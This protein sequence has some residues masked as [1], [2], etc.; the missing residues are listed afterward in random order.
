M[1]KPLATLKCGFEMVMYK[2][3][4]PMKLYS[5]SFT[6]PVGH[7][8]DQCEVTLYSTESGFEFR[9]GFSGT[10][11]VHPLPLEKVGAFVGALHGLDQSHLVHAIRRIAAQGDSHKIHE[12][13]HKT[14]PASWTWRSTDGASG[15]R[16]TNQTPK[17]SALLEREEEVLGELKRP[18]LGRRLT[19]TD[20]GSVVE[21][22]PFVFAKLEPPESIQS[23]E[24]LIFL[25]SARI[26]SLLDEPLV[27][28]PKASA[29]AAITLLIR[30]LDIPEDLTP[31]LSHFDDP[32]AFAALIAA[33][34]H[35]NQFDKSGFPYIEHPRRV[36]LNSQWSLDPATVP[37]DELSAGLQA[38]WLHDVI[39]DSRD[40]F[41][42][43]VGSQDLENWGFN[44]RVIFLVQLLTRSEETSSHNYYR[45][46]SG[47]PTARSVKLAD[48]ADNLASWR[49][50]LLDASTRETLITKYGKALAAL[51]FNDGKESWFSIRIAAFDE[52]LW[53]LFAR[54][55][56]H[57]ALRQKQDRSRDLRGLKISSKRNTWNREL[58]QINQQGGEIIRDSAW[59]ERKAALTPYDALEPYP[60]DSWFAALFI[61]HA[62]AEDT[63]SQEARDTAQ[64]LATFLDSINRAEAQFF[65]HWGWVPRDAN[66][67]QV[68]L[69]YPAAL[70]S[71]H[72]YSDRLKEV[73]DGNYSV[74]GDYHGG[75]EMLLAGATDSQLLDMG[76]IA[77]GE[78][79]P[80]WPS[81]A[82]KSVVIEIEMR[83]R[84]KNGK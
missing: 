75:Q 13:I 1:M 83:T 36:F 37:E 77:F 30:G 55:E 39:E 27:E 16:S 31:G 23:L 3:G 48:I 61:L 78:W 72:N 2:K 43:P 74:E 69:R 59:L 29:M 4:G 65:K 34:V 51:N 71:L 19:L 46:I 25:R 80:A 73:G 68:K 18:T 50:E 66:F 45:L 49:I 67:N 6:R 8:I 76:L 12:I 11:C 60:L 21:I 7:R 58:N 64:S 9:C 62:Q 52:G 53:P 38:A 79:R 81:M 44:K 14:L 41:Y 22:L 42:R 56:S 32:L 28:I 63:G 70:A 47:D 5:F 84:R 40:S 35:A 57:E 26:E 24:N 33:A 10:E 17:D 54:A 15:E 82:M 20:V